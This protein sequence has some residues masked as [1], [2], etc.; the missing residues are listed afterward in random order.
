MCL[1]DLCL[2]YMNNN[3][4]AGFIP[5]YLFKDTELINQLSVYKTNM[6]MFSQSLNELAM[7]ENP[8]SNKSSQSNG[9]E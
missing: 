2:K 1:N 4:W 8:E 6:R 3:L 7:P 5:N 9:S